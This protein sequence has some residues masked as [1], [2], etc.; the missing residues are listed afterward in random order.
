[1]SRMNLLYMLAAARTFSSPSSESESSGSLSGNATYRDAAT[2]HNGAT[3]EAATPP[4]QSAKVTIVIKGSGTRPETDP[5]CV[6]DP[7][8][9]FEAHYLSTMSVSDGEVYSASVAEGSGQIQTP[10]G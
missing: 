4:A 1:M 7:A 8:G 10:S 5:S 3:Q 6:V 9:K 2:D